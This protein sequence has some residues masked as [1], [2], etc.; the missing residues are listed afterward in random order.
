[1]IPVSEAPIGM[2]KTRQLFPQLKHPSI[3]TGS[4]SSFVAFAPLCEV[5]HFVTNKLHLFPEHHFSRAFLTTAFSCLMVTKFWNL[6]GRGTITMTSS[7]GVVAVIIWAFDG[8]LALLYFSREIRLLT[9]ITE[10]VRTRQHD[11]AGIRSRSG[12]YKRKFLQVHIYIAIM[13]GLENRAI[14]PA[15][16]NQRLKCQVLSG[17]LQV[18]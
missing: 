13:H 8:G 6:L 17:L 12:L 4:T 1:M 14:I 15:P 9:T 18:Q 10:T 7:T 2:R 16:R 5:D 11:S 3:S